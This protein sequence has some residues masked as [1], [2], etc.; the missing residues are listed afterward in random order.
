MMIAQFPP[1]L[2]KKIVSLISFHSKYDNLLV[3]VTET[4]E[5]LLAGSIPN[6]EAD[7]T[8]VSVED[9]GVDFDTEGCDVFLLE[10]TGEM[11]LDEGCLT[12]TTISDEDELVL[13]DNWSRLAFHS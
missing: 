3:S 10:F 1:M 9:H 2:H 11:S 5:L 8:V 13:S 4:S 12:D 6:V 7:G